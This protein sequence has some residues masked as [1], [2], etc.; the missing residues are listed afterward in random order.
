[1]QYEAA[2]TPEIALS[3][4]RDAGSDAHVIAGGTNMLPNLRDRVI[5]PRL[6]ID[7]SRIPQFRE[8]A[9]GSNLI[10]LGPNCTMSDL[11][12][13][14]DLIEG[15]RLIP[16]AAAWFAGPSVRNRA[17]IAG[18]VVD[19]SPAADITVPLLALDAEVEISGQDHVTRLVP[20]QEFVIGPHRTTLAPS[21][22]VTAIIIRRYHDARVAYYKLARRDSLAISI[23]S[24]AILVQL[25]GSICR[26]VRIA[27]GAASPVPF[28][29]IRAEETLQGQVLSPENIARA[30]QFARDEAQ[31][32]TDIRGTSSYRMEMIEVLIKRLFEEIRG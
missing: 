4:L 3:L 8:M 29:A 30:A 27:V 18:N 2:R 26:L 1:M 10:R 24:L 9:C 23:V 15:A 14:P 25:S 17:T 32:I 6:L 11:L 20:I 19:A 31:P 5:Q 7:I 21:E 12:S 22:L 28:R 16:Y 13:S